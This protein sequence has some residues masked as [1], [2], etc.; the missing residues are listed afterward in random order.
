MM[1]VILMKWSQKL[2]IGTRDPTAERQRAC[3]TVVMWNS[4]LSKINEASIQGQDAPA[5]HRFRGKLRQPLS[6]S[7]V[8]QGILVMSILAA[9]V[10]MFQ[11]SLR[12]GMTRCRMKSFGRGSK[13]QTIQRISSRK[14]ISTSGLRDLRITVHDSRWCGSN[15]VAQVMGKVRGMVSWSWWKWEEYRGIRYYD[16][17]SDLVDELWLHRVADNLSGL[18]FQEWDP[19]ACSDDTSAVVVML[20]N[21]SELKLQGVG[22]STFVLSVENDNDFRSRCEWIFRHFGSVKSYFSKFL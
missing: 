16:G 3:K 4:G 9:S 15:L 22:N 19:S 11:R 1:M 6:R 7:S 17:D 10:V 5:K 14:R 2:I 20:I 12:E 13:E 8:M 21:L 18:T